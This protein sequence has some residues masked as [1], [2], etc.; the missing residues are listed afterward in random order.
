VISRRLVGRFRG[1][2]NEILTW[3]LGD[4]RFC[5][6]H[7]PQLKDTKTLAFIQ[8]GHPDDSSDTHLTCR[9]F[10]LVDILSGSS[11]PVDNR[12]VSIKMRAYPFPGIER[13]DP[14]TRGVP[15]GPGV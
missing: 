8:S 7:L 4:S 10:S 6:C 13:G 14:Q 5:D 11:L 9:L 15:K 3:T 1:D 12:Q 2:E